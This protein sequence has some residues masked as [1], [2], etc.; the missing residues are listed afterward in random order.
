MRKNRGDVGAFNLDFKEDK[1]KV[2]EKK[3][4]LV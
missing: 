4:T 2:Q 1:K 3:K